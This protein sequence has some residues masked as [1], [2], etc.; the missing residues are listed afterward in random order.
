MLLLQQFAVLN[1]HTVSIDAAVLL[2]V[3]VSVTGV[4]WTVVFTVEVSLKVLTLLYAEQ[5]ALA[6]GR[7]VFGIKGVIFAQLIARSFMY[8]AAANVVHE[9]N[10]MKLRML[11][12]F[13]GE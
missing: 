3:T 6:D 13:H 8:A 10:T 11:L 4:T 2:I 12:N 5:N 7:A 9:R 1:P